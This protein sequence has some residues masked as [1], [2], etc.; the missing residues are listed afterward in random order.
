MKK[1][2]GL[3]AVWVAGMT[4]W[5]GAA[6]PAIGPL[7]AG[8]TAFA[9]ELYAQ[10]RPAEGNLFMSPYSIASALAMTYAGA[11][12]DTAA[13]MEEALHFTLGQE[14]TLSS[15]SALQAR[16]GALQAGGGIQLTIA[17][18][19]WPQQGVPLLPEYLSRVKACTDSAITPLDF[20]GDTEGARGTIN[21]WVEEKTQDKIRDLIARGGLDPLTRLV[22]VNAIY[23]KG[24]WESPFSPQGTGEA[25]FFIS[26][27]AE[28]RV[29]MMVQTHRFPYAEMEDVQIVELPYAGGGV[30]MRVA[31][32]KEKDGLTALEARLTPEILE[33]WRDALVL[34]EVRVFLPKFKMRWG[35]F[36]LNGPLKALGMADAFDE[37]R[38]DFSGMDGRPKWLYIGA[39]L[40]QAFVEVNEEGTEAAAATAV[41]MKARG[42]PMPPAVFRADHPFLFLIQEKESGAILFMGRMTDPTKA[43]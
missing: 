26:P 33:E 2:V 35:T 41:V 10:L 19:L 5:A 32:P 9:L 6:E 31:L 7:V 25:A 36:P 22:L 17:N 16:L 4:V 20:M 14:G 40:H 8:Q 13:E 42:M 43:E 28:V 24:K 39:V 34:R 1:V 18:S 27:E 29:P 37:A 3:W 11:R 12:G 38:A 21:R 30:S 15:F 23:F